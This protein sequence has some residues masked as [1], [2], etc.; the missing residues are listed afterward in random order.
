M[1]PEERTLLL[2]M[3]K[4]I[5]SGMDTPASVR[6]TIRDLIEVVKKAAQEN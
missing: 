4:E 2:V 6:I 5:M 3:A 1:T